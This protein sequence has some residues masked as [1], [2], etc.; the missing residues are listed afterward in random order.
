MIAIV[1]TLHTCILYPLWKEQ[2]VGAISK[3]NDYI[4]Q[5]PEKPRNVIEDISVF[6]IKILKLKQMPYILDQPVE[7]QSVNCNFKT[8]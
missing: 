5:N 4:T 3:L 2:S 1:E 7:K 6:V 8:K